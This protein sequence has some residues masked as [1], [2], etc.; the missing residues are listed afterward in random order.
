LNEVDITEKDFD[1]GIFNHDDRL[2]QFHEIPVQCTTS[3]WLLLEV[4]GSA[5]DLDSSS[6]HW[7]RDNVNSHNRSLA[8]D[9]DALDHLSCINTGDR[10]GVPQ[11]IS[12]YWHVLSYSSIDSSA[13]LLVLSSLQ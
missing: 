5:K 8:L 11:L 7:V 6:A 10:S 3:L 1:A 4:S 13:P 12:L 2:S 9:H